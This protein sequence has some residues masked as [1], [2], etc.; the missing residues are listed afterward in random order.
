MIVLFVVKA[1]AQSQNV[2]INTTGNLPD[3]SAILDV[4][5]TDKGVLIPRMTTAQRTLILSPAKGLLVYDTNFDEFWYFNGT[6]W[7]AF[8]GSGIA[9]P[10]GPTGAAGM[11]GL[12]GPTGPT[13]AGVQGPTGPTGI[14]GT[15]GPVG[16]IGPTGAG[17]QGPTGAIGPT[18][19]SGSGTGPTGP[20]GADGVTGPTGPAG[21]G[22]GP[23]GPTGATGA[24]GSNGVTGA[25]GATGSTG[26]S[27]TLST[28]TYNASGTLTLNGTAGSGGPLTTTGSSWLTLGNSGTVAGTNF[29]GT[30]DAQA[31]VIKT[32][33]SAAT[34]EK[35]RILSTPQ[36]VVNNTAAATGD[37]FSI[38]GSGYTGAINTV[39]NQ[40][41]YPFNSYSTGTFAGIYGENT[42]TGQGVLGNNTS[43]G[44]GL[45]GQSNTGTGIYGT[46]TTGSGIRGYSTGAAYVGVGGYNTNISGTGMIGIGNNI[47]GGSIMANGSGV[48]GNGT[49]CGIFGYG[50]TVASGI[51]IIGEGNNLASWTT[52]A[53]GAGV[54]GQG[55]TFG[56]AGYG[57]ISGGAVVNNK[58]G[59]YFSFLPSATTYSY[60]AGRSGGLDYGILS[61]GAKST[62]VKDEN[63]NNRVLYCTE[64]P[65][66]LFQDFGTGQLVNGIV[67][68]SMDPLFAKSI[69]S[70]NQIR[71]FI[72]LEGDCKG[73]FVK[74]KSNNGFDVVELQGGTS[75]VNFTWQVVGNRANTYDS[76]GNLTNDYSNARFPIGPDSI[77]SNTIDNKTI[78]EVKMQK[79][80]KLMKR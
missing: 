21:S 34:N 3:N 8:G 44:V 73:V 15:T 31:L 60:I 51:G 53:S 22:T 33:G 12:T 5:S 67:H 26:P 38:Y 66:V 61:G 16:P 52:P 32:S 76:S 57:S 71:V 41:D 40:T 37:L 43:S 58:W 69:S 63:G 45:Y 20:T 55:E 48:A 72:Q 9:G 68:I 39:A 75:N 54:S 17:V 59:G 46:S 36:I 42:G 49:A 1:N 28:L 62:M 7:V 25:T 24:N 30:T 27:W 6:I 11:D 79:P 65:E 13:G 14:D 2:S 47:A 78:E 35:M 56:V 10:T 19:P 74:N 4:S 77:K 50:T 23:T 80:S 29:V 18:G 70:E 64:A